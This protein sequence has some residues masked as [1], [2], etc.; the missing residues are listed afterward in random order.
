MV[1]E[2]L[3]APYVLEYTYRRSCGPVIGRFL[4]GLKAGHFMGARTAAGKVLVPPREYDPATGEDVVELVPVKA[5]GEVLTW[6][7]VPEPRPKHPLDR[8]F[9]WALVRL[10]GADTGMLHVVDAGTMERM[11]TGMRVRARWQ[12][13]EERT[14][15][16]RDVLCFE[17]AELSGEEGSG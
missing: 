12:D 13:P 5:E 3:K 11:R 4:G 17:P 7:W 10:D 8:P 14:G 16:V 9:A 6:S 2:V 1:D 15:S